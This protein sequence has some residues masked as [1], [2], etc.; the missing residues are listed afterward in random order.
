MNHAWHHAALC[1]SPGVITIII[2]KFYYTLFKNCQAFSYCKVEKGI[3]HVC[4]DLSA[5]CAHEGEQ[6]TENSAEELT[7]R[8][9]KRPLT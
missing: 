6:G 7:Q 8:N 9:S 1:H 4:N 5:Y 3:F 2:L